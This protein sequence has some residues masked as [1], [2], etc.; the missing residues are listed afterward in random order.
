MLRTPR[1]EEINS[2][3]IVAGAVV[4]IQSDKLVEGLH[5]QNSLAADD[6]LNDVVVDNDAVASK[7]QLAA[8]GR[9]SNGGG[10]VDS[11]YSDS[12]YLGDGRQLDDGSGDSLVGL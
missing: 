12:G 6:Q 2:G 1:L 8:G 7:R 3:E 5:E 11:D 4:E 10:A 9:G